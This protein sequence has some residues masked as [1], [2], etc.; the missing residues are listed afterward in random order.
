[1]VELGRSPS[2]AG[3]RSPRPP[4]AHDEQSHDQAEQP[5]LD[6][7]PRMGGGPGRGHGSHCLP[8]SRGNGAFDMG[9]APGGALVSACGAARRRR[10]TRR[11]PRDRDRRTGRTCRRRASGACRR[12]AD[13][14][15]E[16]LLLGACSAAGRSGLRA[17]MMRSGASGRTRT[18]GRGMSNSATREAAI[19]ARATHAG[20]RRSGRRSRRRRCAGPAGCRATSVAVLRGVVPGG[21][22]ADDGV[23]ERGRRR[24]VRGP[25]GPAGFAG[26]CRRRVPR[27][28]ACG[29]GPRPEGCRG[30]CRGTRS[31]CAVRRR[32]RSSISRRRSTCRSRRCR[33][34]RRGSPGA[35]AERARAAAGGKDVCRW[36]RSRRGCA[37]AG[38]RSRARRRPARGCGARAVEHGRC[39]VRAPTQ[40]GAHAARKAVRARSARPL[41][42]RLVEPR[43]VDDPAAQQRADEAV[44]R[45]GDAGERGPPSVRATPVVGLARDEQDGTDHEVAPRQVDDGRPWWVSMAYDACRR[46][47]GR[48][49][50]GCEPREA[51]Q[52]GVEDGEA[53]GVAPDVEVG[54]T[55]GRA[56]RV[57]APWRPARPRGCPASA[58]WRRAR[59][60][61]S[62]TSSRV[63]RTGGPAAGAG[64]GPGRAVAACG[65]HEARLLA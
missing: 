44:G 4:R 17:W 56:P 52:R 12:R 37:V 49:R 39:R 22:A 13:E 9:P 38:L 8:E 23:V 53:G 35:Q 10:R 32:S 61:A 65:C 33:R 27:R 42:A 31:S 55:G 34:G 18:S 46:R 3:G 11:G 54:R 36:P 19:P 7:D 57:V 43:A 41:D 2:R 20:R 50:A 26:A 14:G 62:K 58:R 30:P 45:A 1:M 51:G 40:L 15:A 6:D 48:R 59:A 28:A 47:P 25:L 29:P 16:A 21:D 60:R 5:G 64:R 63:G 24:R